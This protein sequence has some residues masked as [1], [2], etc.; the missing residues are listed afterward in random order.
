M[1]TAMKEYGMIAIGSGS[2]AS[3]LD[4]WLSDNPAE[5]GAVIEKDTVGGICLTRG[6]IPSKMLTTCADVVQTVRRAG[7]FGIDVRGVTIDFGRIMRRLHEHIDPDI[8]GIRAGLSHS[9]NIDFFPSVAEFVGPSTVRVGT[10]TLHSSRILLGLG[11]QPLIPSIPGLAEAGYLTSDTVFGLTERPERLAILGGGYIAAEFAHFFAAVGTEVSVVGRNP[12]FL[13][14]EEPEVSEV[15]TRAL[16][17]R[18]L[19]HLGTT[20]AKIEGGRR[21]TKRLHTV[22]TSTQA[23]GLLEVNEILVATGRGPSTSML[24]PERSGINTDP[25]GWVVVN[26]FLETSQPGIWALGDATGKFPFKHKANHDAKVLYRNLVGAHRSPVDYHAIPHAVFTE[27]EVASVGLT[28]AQG[29]AA[30]GRDAVWLNQYP[31]RDTA[32]GQALGESEGFV[33]VIALDGGRQILG[34]HIVGP[35]AAVLLQ[36]I[37]NLLY[38][39]EQS[40]M[41]IFDGMHIH[42]ALSEVVERAVLGLHPLSAG[43]PEVHGHRS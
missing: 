24:H 6:C 38:T 10:E 35:Q 33:K 26:E 21:G 9:P 17:K 20:V 15:V 34:A 31:Y 1:L 42:P 28:E 3:V 27:P 19:F 30:H 41:P 40:L 37:V 43:P 32:K 5:R 7:E 23:N 4:S 2:A 11:S 29:V 18:I 22:G 8:E 13:P 16:A 36:E 12:R 25:Q 14:R 39:P